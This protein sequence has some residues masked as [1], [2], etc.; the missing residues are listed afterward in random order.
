MELSAPIIKLHTIA[1]QLILLISAVMLLLI[2]H[3]IKRL[4][5]EILAAFTLVSFFVAL[6][7][8]L[9]LWQHPD[10]GFNQ[11]VLADRFA[12]ALQLIFLLGGMLSVLVSLN[13]VEA[14]YLHFGDFYALLQFAIIGLMVMTSSNHLLIIFLG[15]EILSIALYVLAGIRKMRVDSVEAA[16]KYFLLGAFATGFFLYGAALLYGATGSLDIGVMGKMMA[17][18][19]SNALLM[20]TGACLLF[21][22]L[23]FKAAF[24]PFHM[25]TPDVYQGAPT[26]VVAFM[27]TGTKAAALAVL[28]RM[29]LAVIPAQVSPWME[30]L[31]FIAA[32]T[33]TVGNLM[34]IVQ[35]NV[36]RMMAYSSISHAGYLL[37]A[38]TAGAVW[39]S[40]AIL[41]YLLV[42]TLMN[43]GA[44][45]V[46]SML[47]QS[48]RAERLRFED[49][50][51]LGY[52]YPFV[53]L[54]MTIF[55]VSL[56]GIPPTGGFMGKF[57]L[58]SVAVKAGY[59]K[60]VVIA[61]INSVI[62]VYYYLR[63]V[64]NMYMREEETELTLTWPQ[65]GLLAVLIVAV[66]GV[67]WLGIAPES[68]Y[69]L[70]SQAGF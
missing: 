14:D 45:A 33:M 49:Y 5:R 39:A 20:L 36:K 13:R 6:Y 64:V 9:R 57:Y 8:V 26:P 68:M 31:P 3:F 15:L 42:Y 4:S 1:P 58:F 34:A 27:S 67:L 10:T 17:V 32:L 55:M 24:V 44:F 16:F 19:S 60:L 11:M 18:K 65:Q 28:C 23:A 50:R 37:V 12:M 52:R 66:I 7:F 35:N 56:A 21:I 69:A 43:I 41:Y 38:L 53:A 51:G 54:T 30:I 22:G 48:D 46:I 59:V 62:S 47:G 25:W 40:P 61:V 63:L 2:P 70:F 29:V